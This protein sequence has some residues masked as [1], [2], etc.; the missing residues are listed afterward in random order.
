MDN[1]AK[2]GAAAYLMSGISAT[3]S[4]WLSDR[5]IVRGGTPTRVRKAFAG[6][7]LGMAGIVLAFCP[8]TGPFTCGALLLIGLT[9]F[10]AA[11]SNVFAVSQRLAGPQAAGRWTGFQNAFGNLAGVV[12]PVVTGFIVKNTGS[13]Q[14]AFVAVSVAALLGTASYYFV[15]GPVEQVTWRRTARRAVAVT[16]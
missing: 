16:A 5:W 13:F 8:F 15:V 7:A 14:W 9:F 12:V 10:G 3:V 11:A 4:G 6:G 2:L 1:M